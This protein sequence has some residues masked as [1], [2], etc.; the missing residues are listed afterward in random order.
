MLEFVFN[1]HSLEGGCAGNDGLGVGGKDEIV[2]LEGVEIPLSL[3][4]SVSVLS[5]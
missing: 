3:D 2:D 4:C 1:S 5:I